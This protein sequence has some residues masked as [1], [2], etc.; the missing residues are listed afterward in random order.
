MRLVVAAV[1]TLA[2]AACGGEGGDP[3]ITQDIADATAEQYTEC[4]PL[5]AEWERVDAEVTEQP[6]RGQLLMAL[7]K[8]MN[9]LGCSR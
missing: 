5:V 9:E 2:L 1:L 7:G 4:G 6:E 8:R 3:G